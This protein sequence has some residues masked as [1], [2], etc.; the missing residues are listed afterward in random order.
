MNHFIRRIA[1]AHSLA[2]LPLVLALA[3]CGGGGDSAS[4]PTPP[5]VAAAL[6][7]TGTAAVGAPMA[8]AAIQVACSAGNATTTADANGVYTITITDGALPCVITATSSD[9]QTELH[10]VA[11]GTGQADTTANVT[12]LS[13]LLVA[14]LSG[15]DPKSFVASFTSSTTIAPADVSAAQTAL[16]QT[17]TAAGVDT[18]AVGNI[19]SG[20]ITAGSGTG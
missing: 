4:T 13:E 11:A 7:M 9:G 18:A 2:L 14:Q 19:V 20:A 5:P 10:S 1:P 16:L 3:A 17:L 6:K 15:G 12:P 8:N